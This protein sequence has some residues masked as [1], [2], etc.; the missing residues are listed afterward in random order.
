MKLK[1]IL[2]ALTLAC[3]LFGG[4]SC[5]K[6]SDFE[7]QLGELESKVVAIEA[8]ISALNANVSSLKYLTEGAVITEV[9]E[10]AT[11]YELTLSDGRKLTVNHGV[12]G[13][14]GA[15]G[16]N[17]T[18]GTDG[19]TPTIS[20]NENG[21]WVI[22]GVVQTVNAYGQDGV[23]PKFSVD[24]DGYWVVS[25][26]NGASYEKVKDADGNPVK[27]KVE[28]VTGPSVEA[29][30]FFSSVQVS[31]NVF[32]LVLRDGTVVEVP[33]LKG[34]SF[35]IKKNGELVD[36]VQEILE[37][38]TVTFDVEQTGVASA[39]IVACPAGF[40]VELTETTL[41]VTALPVTKASAS[42]SKD[43]A[44][45]AVSTKGLS[46]MSKIM[47]EAT[48]PQP[49]A[50]LAN[51]TSE[52]YS[53]NSV[54]LNATLVNG[55]RIH[56]IIKAA[57]ETAAT[58]EELMAKDAVV[59]T[60]GVAVLG[61]SSLEPATAYV[62]YYIASDGTK[63]S[64][65]QTFEF[66]TRAIN[67]N[68]LYEKYAVGQTVTVAGLEI[69][70]A[71]YPAAKLINNS[72]TD[73]N[74]ANNGVYFVASDAT[75]VTINGTASQIIVLSLDSAMATIKR[76]ENKSFYL[77]A[78]ANN[79]YM[80][81]SNIKYETVMT[82]GNVFGIGG[83]GEIENIV[84]NKC[85]IEVPKDMNMLYGAKNI[86][87][88]SMTD[89][90]V[91]LYT[92]TNQKNIVQTNT[93]NTYESLVFKNNIFYCTDGDLTNFR[94]FSNNNATIAS[95]DFRNNTIAGVYASASYGYL[96]VKSITAGNVVS[97]LLY[98]PN[99]TTH[100]DSKYIG[101]LHIADKADAHLNMPSNLAFYNYDAVP[102]YRAKVSYYTSNGTLYNKAKADNPIPSPDY[103]NG[104]FTQADN[105]KS[106]GATR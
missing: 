72:S 89:C 4:T 87:N 22:N 103:G 2:S 13:A 33:I 63:S 56:C 57:A 24:A 18:N 71:T 69:S 59:A 15:N 98:L 9:S 16:T 25:Y 32:V 49:E 100:L 90:D 64:D 6:F 95:L 74:I 51:V 30:T 19:T 36:G 81:F 93:E 39:A 105:Y 55:D 7:K 102:S 46:A 60:E 97:N 1:Q 38:T 23:T 12:K 8:Q 44:I 43:I 77:N 106:F 76:T 70:T 86:A 75:D 91:K 5:S 68:N 20:I 92:G 67:E 99:Y 40:D 66:S 17:G 37:G 11:G 29:D 65:V 54:K 10:T 26:N 45:L 31:G 42:L 27:A 62:A 78:S 50:T 79:D 101:I 52:Y 104:V 41:S 47:V 80:I 94:L 34:F 58:A 28:I 83:D 14:D 96:T 88:F 85:K 21:Y 3:F 48:E 35:V 73:K 84:F 61:K 53:F 82:S